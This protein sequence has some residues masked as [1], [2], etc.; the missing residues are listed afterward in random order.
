MVT[1]A[2][3]TPIQDRKRVNHALKSLGFG[4][5]DDPNLITQVACLI[6]SHEHFRGLLFSVHPDKRRL[7][8]NSLRAHLRFTAKPLDVYELEIKR[9]AEEQQWDLIDPN[10]PA[11]PKAFEVQNIRLNDLAQEA[12]QQTEHEKKGGRLELVCSKCTKQRFF[13]APKRKQAYKDAQAE[14]WRWAERNGLMK[15]YCPEHVPG[16]LTMTLRCSNDDC[17][18]SER[19]RAWDEQDGYAKARVSGWIIG[20]F[21]VCPKCA[22]KKLIIQ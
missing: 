5:L 15:T 14:G 7:A 3:R 17:E 1:L 4:H 11:Y 18:K 21:A 20:D 13:P 8:Y 6:E 16:R 22:V 12:I 10:N 9:L 2:E 19:M